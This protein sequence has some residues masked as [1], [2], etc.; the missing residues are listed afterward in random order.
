MD[1]ENKVLTYATAFTVVAGGVLMLSLVPAALGIRQ[2]Q[3]AQAFSL[4]ADGNRTMSL[5]KTYDA[6]AAAMQ[7]KTVVDQVI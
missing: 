1:T 2:V 5:S 6:K 4:L 7:L 3:R